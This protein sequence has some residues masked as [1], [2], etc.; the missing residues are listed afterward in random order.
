MMSWKD[1]RMEVAYSQV[2]LSLGIVYVSF[3]ICSFFVVFCI[4][5]TFYFYLSR[6]PV[7]C[8]P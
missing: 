7:L 8:F 3:D 5:S 4:A 2:G 6:V 1:F